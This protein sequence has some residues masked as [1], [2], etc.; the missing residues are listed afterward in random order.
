[1]K[2]TL[3]IPEIQSVHAVLILAGNYVLQLRDSK[4]NIAAPGKWGLFGGKVNNG[5]TPLEAIK[6]EVYEELSIKPAEYRHLWCTDYFSPYQREVIRTWFFVSDVTTTWPDHKLKEGK[7][8]KSFQFKQ[9]AKL[10]IPPKMYDALIR[11]HQ[12]GRV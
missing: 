8:V 4:L 9:L 12:Q 2:P 5:E 6:R 10:D 11:F 7:A 1:M 3:N